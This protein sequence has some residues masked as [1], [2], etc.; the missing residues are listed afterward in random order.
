MNIPPRF[1]MI[2]QLLPRAAMNQEKEVPITQ[3][4][5]QS[6]KTFQEKVR[7]SWKGSDISVKPTTWV[8]E[9]TDQPGENLMF[10]GDDAWHYWALW[11]N[12]PSA[13]RLQLYSQV[14]K[15]ALELWV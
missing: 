9:N 2:L 3:E 10:I 8:I 11:E 7:A 12:L 4:H 1:G 6:L 13:G 14:R 15:N 5:L